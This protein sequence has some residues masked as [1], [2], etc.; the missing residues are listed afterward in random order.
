[1]TTI[2]T[3]AGPRPQPEPP[4]SGRPAR[5]HRFGRRWGGPVKRSGAMTRQRPEP[6][7]ITDADASSVPPRDPARGPSPLV[8]CHWLCPQ[9][10]RAEGGGRTDDTDSP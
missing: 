8:S 2:A 1:A 3:R 6:L 4:P 7:S 5:L 9:A 10:T